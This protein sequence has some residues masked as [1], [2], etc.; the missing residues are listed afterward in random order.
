MNLQQLFQSLQNNR[1][2]QLKETGFEFEIPDEHALEIAELFDSYLDAIKKE[3][4][5]N[6][7]ERLFCL[8]IRELFPELPFTEFAISMTPG[9]HLKLCGIVK[10]GSDPRAMAEGEAFLVPEE[11]I[12]FV[13]E[14]ADHLK[15]N[16][17]SFYWRFKLW[18]RMAE[19]FPQTQQGSWRYLMFAGVPYIVKN[20]E[21][22]EEKGEGSEMLPWVRE[23]LGDTDESKT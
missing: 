20:K 6:L 23:A 16:K 21:E 13:I 10:D 1:P 15:A 3:E 12:A 7:T 4:K 8:K 19:L 9:A 18:R 2:S 14:C 11:E 5:I 17:R 22:E